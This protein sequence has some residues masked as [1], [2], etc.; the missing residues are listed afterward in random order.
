MW[1][2]KKN[3]FFILKAI[4]AFILLTGCC[5]DGIVETKKNCQ[6]YSSTNNKFR[7]Y[8]LYADSKLYRVDNEF[9]EYSNFISY[10]NDTLVFN[11]K[12]HS[13]SY[14][15]FKCY[16]LNTDT[17]KLKY[18]Y[19]FG[20]L[21]ST[22]NYYV[23][24]NG[25]IVKE[26]TKLGAND[27]EYNLDNTIKKISGYSI[28]NYEYYD[29][30]DYINIDNLRYLL[31]KNYNLKTNYKL[32]KKKTDIV[33]GIE[34]INSYKYVYDNSGNVVKMILNNSDTTNYEYKCI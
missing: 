6:L 5:K 1:K 20:N 32:L 4:F 14:S 25:L 21:D 27:Y 17:I 8:Y 28:Q 30:F 12:Y 31:T 22:T 10:K 3:D 13:G 18:E 11:T 7:N 24:K 29:S 19:N 16:K 2:L 15:I 34:T 26:L 9:R 23:I 33:N